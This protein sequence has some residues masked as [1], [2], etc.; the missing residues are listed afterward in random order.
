MKSKHMTVR[1]VWAGESSR[2]VCLVVYV[3]FFSFCLSPGDSQ[4]TGASPEAEFLLIFPPALS[5]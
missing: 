5:I 4:R 2:S 3:F 1:E